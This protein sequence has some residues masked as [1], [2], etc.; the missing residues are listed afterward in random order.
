M[1]KFVFTGDPFAP[2]HD[3]Q[4][5]LSFGMTFKLNGEP[6]EAPDD[7]IAAKLRRHS[8]FTEAKETEVADKPR[9]GRP[10]KTEQAE[11]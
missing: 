4:T 5:C 10:P 2:G 1:A 3:P 6:V 11:A 8:H 7:E 9:R